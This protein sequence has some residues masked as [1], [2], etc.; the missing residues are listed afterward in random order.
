MYMMFSRAA[1]VTTNPAE[2]PTGTTPSNDS[3]AQQKPQNQQNDTSEIQY[4][5]SLSPPEEPQTGSED[6]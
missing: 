5:P 3:S 2:P 4:A 1:F 6:D